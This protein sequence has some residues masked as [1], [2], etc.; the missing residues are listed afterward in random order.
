MKLFKITGAGKSR[1]TWI[2]ARSL[3]SGTSWTTL[4]P[5]TTSRTLSVRTPNAHPGSLAPHLWDQCLAW[6]F[7]AT[8]PACT[9]YVSLHTLPRGRNYIYNH[10]LVGHAMPCYIMVLTKPVQ[11][12]L[13]SLCTTPSFRPVLS[14]ADGYHRRAGRP[15]WRRRQPPLCAPWQH[16]RGQRGRF[17]CVPAH[18]RELHRLQRCRSQ[19]RG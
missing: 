18:Q 16:V 7:N 13:P 9:Q 10:L 6:L 11:P 2:H 4:L 5:L 15:H 3:R 14:P 12:H 19:N 1:P 8:L 17:S